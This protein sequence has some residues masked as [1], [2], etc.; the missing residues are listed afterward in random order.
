[1]KR[2][3]WKFVSKSKPV[4]SNIAF[5]SESLNVKLLKRKLSKERR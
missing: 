2:M 3:E 5:M 4:F 1:M